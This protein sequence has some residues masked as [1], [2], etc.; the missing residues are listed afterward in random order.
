MCSYPTALE[1]KKTPF[2]VTSRLVP[3]LTTEPLD[4]TASI[5]LPSSTPP[6]PSIGKLDAAALDSTAETDS[7]IEPQS[8]SEI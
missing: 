2:V 7:L 5:P 3:M 8:A 6:L 1:Y 4:T